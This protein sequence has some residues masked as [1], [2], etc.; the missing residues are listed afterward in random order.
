[1]LAPGSCVFCGTPAAAGERS[2]CSGCFADMPWCEPAAAPLPGIFAC[3]VAM[4]RYTFPVDA[5]IKAM[6]FSRRLHYLPAFAEILQAARPLLP[7]DIDAVLPVPLHWRRKTRRG[8]NQA[9]ELAKPVAA[10]LG[11]PV[12]RGVRRVRATRY[13]SGLDAG[14]RAANLRAAF[15]IRGKLRCGH[16][17]LVDDIV[18]TGSTLNHL[19]KLLLRNGVDRVSSLTVA[20]ASRGSPGRR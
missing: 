19:A 6:K 12:V 5:A 9:G 2:I 18:T 20:R 11:V 4:L 16:P 10:M 13:Q 1:M 17:L 3:S 15:A 14:A 7:A 8:F